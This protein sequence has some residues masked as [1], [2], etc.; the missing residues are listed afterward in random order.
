MIFASGM[1]NASLSLAS[2][3]RFSMLG[4]SSPNAPMR[5]NP[6]AARFMKAARSG[7]NRSRRALAKP[8]RSLVLSAEPATMNE[9]PKGAFLAGL[10]VA[11]VGHELR[12]G[13]AHVVLDVLIEH[14]PRPRAEM[15]H[16]VFAEQPARI[17][18]PL[19]VLVSRGVKHQARVLRRPCGQH[20]DARLLHLP[21][22]LGV[23]ILDAGHLV[24][25]RV[26]EHARD[27]R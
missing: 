15:R 10:A 17:G 11:V 18:E 4:N 7:P 1:P 6:R 26:G 9:L 19:G 21:L 20:H 13:G 3:M 27:G 16:H 14:R 5:V 24:A 2:S 8:P 22:L 12:A 23:V 25:R